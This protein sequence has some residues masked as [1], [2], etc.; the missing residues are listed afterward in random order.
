M[1]DPNS[2][3]KQFPIFSQTKAG[4]SWAFLDSAASAQKPQSVLDAMDA[5]YKT[6]YAN[7][8]RGIY[9]LAEEATRQYE[10]ARIEIAKFIGAQEPTEII[11][12]KNTTESIN[13]V[14]YSVSSMLKPGDEILVTEMEHHANLIPWQQAAARA[15]AKLR[16]IP[17]GHD[18]RL[19]ISKLDEL[20]N[21]KTKIVAVTAMSNA[22]GTVNDIKLIIHI[23]HKLGAWVLIDAAQAAAHYP[24]NVKELDCEFLA[25]SGHKIFGPSGVGVLYGKKDILKKIPPF[26]TGGHMIEDVWYDRA[27]WAEL[28]AKFE[29]GTPPISEVIGLGE[30]VKFIYKLGWSNIIEHERSLTEYGLAKL[31][32]VKGLKL[33]GPSEISS[34][35]SL[36][37]F[38][39]EK[40]HAHDVAG[41][42]NESGVAV[43]V[44]HHC[45]AP[46]HKKFGL[47][48]TTRASCSIYNTAED[49]DRLVEALE[50][51]KKML[52]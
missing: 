26:L 9:D 19:D 37:S 16:L 42:L 51:A 43:R 30:A 49:I 21:S 18:F 36:F 22:L 5:V 8:H 31:K 44:G 11:F 41:I 39:L 3:K 2:I 32:I 20:I 27:T 6:T 40:V 28:P 15:G 47:V 23:A 34:R 50:K 1:L 7:I 52:A 24:I 45:N 13:L 29:A 14:A 48:A 17:V 4:K 46:L 35:G 10:E 33:F 25:F 38:T 12:T